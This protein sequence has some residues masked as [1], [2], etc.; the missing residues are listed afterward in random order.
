MFEARIAQGQV[1]KKL[2]DALKELITEGNL[3]ISSSGIQLQAMDTSHVCLVSLC[4]GD[5]GFDHYRCDRN[6]PLGIH[7]TNLAKILKCA[8]VRASPPESRAARLAPAAWAD[9]HSNLHKPTAATIDRHS[10]SLCYGAVEPESGAKVH[11][12]TTTTC[13][14]RLPLTRQATTT[15]S[16]S[17]PRTTPTR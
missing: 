7:F 13:P 6:Q 10:R 5:E 14:T 15:P 11:F 12:S 17:R 9:P 3:D 1:L 8:G 4:L 2:V 16:P